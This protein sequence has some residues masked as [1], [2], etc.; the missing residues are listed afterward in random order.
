MTTKQNADAGSSGE[1]APTLVS[2][3]QHKETV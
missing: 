2:E 3:L 1:P